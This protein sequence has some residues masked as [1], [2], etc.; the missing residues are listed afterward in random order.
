MRI[1]LKRTTAI[2]LEAIITIVVYAMFV[3]IDWR[4]AIAMAL[5]EVSNVLEE[6]LR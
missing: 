2:I 1:R 4:L 5:F 6:K 3:W